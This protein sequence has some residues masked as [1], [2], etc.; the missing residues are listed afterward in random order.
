MSDINGSVETPQ[1]PAA[2]P[3]DAPSP[4][5]MQSMQG[6]DAPA[7]V[8]PAPVETPPAA[9]EAPVET[10]PV[11]GGAG[12]RSMQGVED[13]PPAAPVDSPST[14]AEPEPVA[15]S[16]S[17]APAANE[18]ETTNK[19][20]I[21]KGETSKVDKSN[22][23][24][25]D[26][27]LNCSYEERFNHTPKNDGTWTGDRG[28]SKWVPDDPDVQETL[29][30][31]GTDGIEYKNCFPDFQPVTKFTAQLPE[32]LLQKS[33]PEQFKECNRQLLEAVENDPTFAKTFSAIDL[34]RLS[35]GENPVDCTWHH[36]V[37]SGTM[38]LIP[39]D[40]HDSCR[41]L[42]GRRI[43]GGGNANR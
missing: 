32:E 27:A 6:G 21:G 7:A 22:P 28:E 15:K 34:Q 9:P 31:S 14:A 11:R 16:E 30:D 35:K 8:A 43:W 18:K 40:I 20:E 25:N 2:A 26:E 17:V 10:P 29:S 19:Q 41:H 4:T 37:T 33:D 38:R 23:E 42:G 5:A 36:D 13:T 1:A 12:M 3:A 24:E 39:T